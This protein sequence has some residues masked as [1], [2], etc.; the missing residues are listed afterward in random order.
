MTAL[1][2]RIGVIEAAFAQKKRTELPSLLDRRQRLGQQQVPHQQL[3]QDRNIAKTF[4]VSGAQAAHQRVARKTSDAEHGAQYACQDNGDDCNAQRVGQTDTK[5][6]PVGLGRIKREKTLADRKTGRLL[7][8]IKTA[9]DAA[10][11]HVGERVGGQKPDRQ[12][13]QSDRNDLVDQP[14]ERLAAPGP[15]LF[16]AGSF[17]R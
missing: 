15:V 1:P 4:D 17:Y 5:S 8:K 16:Q 14:P 6:A 12:C 13:D 3:Q 2:N 10:H 11:A 9:L 7:Q